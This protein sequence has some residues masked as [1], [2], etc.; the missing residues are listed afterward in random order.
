MPRDR[1]RR[2]LDELSADDGSETAPA[3]LCEVCADVAQLTGA[4]IMLLTADAPQ[5]SVCSSNTV[6]EA[7]EELQYTLVEGPSL[8]AHS[9]GRPVLEPDLDNNGT[10]RWLA[11]T[12]AA[13]AA[14]ARAVFA[15]PMVVGA[16]RFGAL[17]LYRDQRGPLRDEQYGDCLMLAGVAAQAVLNLQAQ[18]PPGMLGAVL[19]R[20]ASGHYVVHQAAG[21]VAVQ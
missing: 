14:G 18:A 11:F 19:E 20:G 16:A 21:M 9:L 15:F 12:P 3:R 2:I 1:L 4:G 13:V 7:L 10:H 5:G 6:S 8:D 17:N